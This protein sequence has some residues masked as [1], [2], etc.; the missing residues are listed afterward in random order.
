MKSHFIFALLLTVPLMANNIFETV[1]EYEKINI[2][3]TVVWSFL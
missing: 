2:H 3:I 1:T